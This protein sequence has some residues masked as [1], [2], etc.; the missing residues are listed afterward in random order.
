MLSCSVI[1]L[2]S[3]VIYYTGGGVCIFH[4]D[5]EMICLFSIEAKDLCSN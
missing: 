3:C 4:D 5:E 2:Y 1:Q